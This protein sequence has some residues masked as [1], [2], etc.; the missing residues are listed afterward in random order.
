MKIPSSNIQIRFNTEKEK[1]NPDQP[2][3]RVL[4]N[5]IEELAETV[6]INVPTVTSE[7]LLPSG[8]KKWHISCRGQVKWT[9]KN[10]RID[11]IRTSGV[12]WLTGLP[13]SG[14]TTLALEIKNLVLDLNLKCVHLDGDEIRKLF[15]N[16]GFSK[17]DRD[18]HI[19]RVGHLASL[20][21]EQEAIVLVSLVSSVRAAR[22]FSRSLCKNFFEVHVNTPLEICEERDNKGL[23]RKARLGEIQNFTGVSDPFEEPENP[24]LRISSNSKSATEISR[25]IFETYLKQTELKK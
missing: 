7:D 15:P 8:Q 4:I 5:G 24:E 3:W 6:E 14:K 2:A 17:E 21:E 19:K 13:C 12:I 9:N 10:C 1:T 22:D 18:Q 23:Y 20:L 16:T 11:P 25:I